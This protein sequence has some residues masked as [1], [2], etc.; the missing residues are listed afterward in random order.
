MNVLVG[1]NSSGKSSLLRLFLEIETATLSGED[2]ANPDQPMEVSLELQAIGRA[3]AEQYSNLSKQ[4]PG[5]HGELVFRVVPRKGLSQIIKGPASNVNKP[6]FGQPLRLPNNL[7]FPHL[8]TRRTAGYSEQLNLDR[9]NSVLR[10]Y[11][12][13]YSKVDRLLTGS[14]S[15]RQEFLAQCKEI[16]GIDISSFPS[17]DGKMIG[18]QINTFRNIPMPRMG[19]GIPNVLGLLADLALAENAIFLMEE[20]ENDLHPKA[21]R[22]LLKLVIRSSSANQFIISTHSNV[23]LRELGADA[24]TN[25]FH[26][27]A[28]FDATPTRTTIEEVERDPQSRLNVLRELGYDA[29][30]LYMNTAWLILEESSAERIIREFLIPWFTPEL[31]AVLRTLAAGGIDEVEPRFVDFDRLFL[32]M[33]LEPIYH[34]RAWVMV[35]GDIRGKEVVQ[36]LQTQFSGW[37]PDRFSAFSEPTFERYYPKQFQKRVDEALA[38]DDKKAKRAAKKQL[39]DAVLDWIKKS[40]DDAK[41]AF[42]ESAQEVIEQLRRIREDLQEG[43]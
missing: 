24:Q 5:D 23:V 13:L 14:D 4:F 37:T 35:D 30:D 31:M 11:D 41:I 3:R 43:S 32:F 40:P 2:A 19:D 29:A 21:L 12:N 34:D 38:N 16:L 17:A 25:V 22:K 9:A 27:I 1:P 26:T 28:D 39:L 36:Q 7:I 33:H 18:Q 20:P 42:E 15:Q 6:N 8:S 10:T